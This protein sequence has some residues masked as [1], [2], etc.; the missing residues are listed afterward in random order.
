MPYITQ[1][2]TVLRLYFVRISTTLSS[3]LAPNGGQFIDCPN[4]LFFSTTGQTLSAIDT[5]TAITLPI[6]YL[7]NAVYVDST[8]TSRVYCSVGGIY[9][10]Q[11]SGQLVSNSSNAKQVYVW[12]KRNGTTIG[13]TTHQY[14]L[15]GS[16]EHMAVEWNFNIDMQ[17]GQYLELI[18]AA[19]STD[20]EMEVS[21]AA[22]PHPGIPSAVLAVNFIAPLPQ[23][24]PT[25]P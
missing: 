18:W 9:N 12:I 25:P 8:Y 20:V 24:L 1:L 22:S 7:S 3:L 11:F 23:V 21:A 6:T 4:G 19:D 15:S 16:N 2:L 10:F 14:T 13:Y 5:A 17:A